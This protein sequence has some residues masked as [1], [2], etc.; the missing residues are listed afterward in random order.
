LAALAA[1][2]AAQEPGAQQGLQLARTF[3]RAL[4]DGP[5]GERL[6]GFRAHYRITERTPLGPTESDMTLDA[7]PGGTL[8]D[9]ATSRWRLQAKS[10]EEG[11]EA[12]VAGSATGTAQL[13]E[14]DRLP[15]LVHRQPAVLAAAVIAGAAPATATTTDCGGVACESLRVELSEG[16]I[17]LLAADPATHLP[18]WMRVWRL[19]HDRGRPAD[20]EI[21][22]DDWRTVDGVR[23]AGRMDVK[24][25]FGPSRRLSLVEWIWKAH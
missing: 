25:V 9:I 11:G 5:V 23:I 16:S 8:L 10:T 19:G 7:G 2:G 3:L 22:Y 6:P 14:A 17:L 21:T 4:T 15:A 20:E 1:P 13:P 18:R 12:H 24:D